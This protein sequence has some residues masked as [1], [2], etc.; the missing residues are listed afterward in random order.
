MPQARRPSV[1]RLAESSRIPPKR[2][3]RVRKIHIKIKELA[4][5]SAAA[6]RARPGRVLG[7]MLASSGS[8]PSGDDPARHPPPRNILVAAA[9]SS[10]PVPSGSFDAK[11]TLHDERSGRQAATNLPPADKAGW[12]AVGHTA[13]FTA[14]VNSGASIL[15]QPLHHRDRRV[16]RRPPP[17]RERRRRRSVERHPV[18]RT[19]PAHG[20]PSTKGI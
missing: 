2:Q 17:L 3:R 16:P 9:A 1:E 18:E 20:P 19:T 14:R 4:N 15:R 6:P 13:R 8:P 12:P 11:C 10:R 5:S 7:V